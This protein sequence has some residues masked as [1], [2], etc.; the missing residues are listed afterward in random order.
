MPWSSFRGHAFTRLGGQQYGQTR[1][2]TLIVSRLSGDMMGQFTD[3]LPPMC[4]LFSLTLAFLS[5]YDS[6]LCQGRTAGPAPPA[7]GRNWNSLICSHSRCVSAALLFSP[8]CVELCPC[9]SSSQ[10]CWASLGPVGSKMFR[11][12]SVA[13][14]WTNESLFSPVVFVNLGVCVNYKF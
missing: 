10:D 9:G 2:K 4:P 3:H 8:M 11:L 14:L 6:P 12:G 1:I 7:G 5:T 13:F